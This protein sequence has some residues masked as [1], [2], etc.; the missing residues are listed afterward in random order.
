M[1]AILWGKGTEYQNKYR[2]NSNAHIGDW[3]REVDNS[4]VI[5][6][7]A[8]NINGEISAVIFMN[9]FD[10]IIVP[11]NWNNQNDRHVSRVVYHTIYCL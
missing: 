7:D 3:R 2:G 1:M 6:G 8:C 5:M 11:Q 9:S 10:V 4:K